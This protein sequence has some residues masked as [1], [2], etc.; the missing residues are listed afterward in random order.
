M[1]DF[2]HVWAVASWY[3]KTRGEKIHW[4]LPEA[5]GINCPSNEVAH[6]KKLESLLRYQDF[7]SDVSFV[8]T[9]WSPFWNPADFGISGEYYNFG[10]WG[11]PTTYFSQFYA[12]RYDLDYDKQYVIKYRD[13]DVPHYDNV[14]IETAPWRDNIGSLQKIIPPGSVELSH[15]D[16]VERNINLAVK[17]K[18]VWTNG[19]GFSIMLDL[20]N[21]STIIFKSSMEHG[22]GDPVA[23][24]HLALPNQGYVEHRYILY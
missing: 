14:W 7:T 22:I 17:A 19:G 13:V 16:D 6:Y 3:Y 15:S 21:K 9:P 2:L 18:N 1:G 5:T 11:R 20:C 4:V 12:D 24:R 8:D 23:F 10:V